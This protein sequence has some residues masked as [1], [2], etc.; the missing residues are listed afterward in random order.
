MRYRFVLIGL[1]LVAITLGFSKAV[2]AQTPTRR[3]IEVRMTSYKFEPNHVRFNEG[4]TVAIRLISADPE[5]DQSHSI[6]ARYLMNIPVTIRGESRDY[7]TGTFEG[8][9]WINVEQGKQVDI[10]FVAT[11]R[12]S[13]PFICGITDHAW[14]GQTGAFFV[15]PTGSQ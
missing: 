13:F 9:R 12:G 14:R 6:A 2:P 10:E 7:R 5:R 4:D 11:G 3:V 8:Q 1:L 15:Q